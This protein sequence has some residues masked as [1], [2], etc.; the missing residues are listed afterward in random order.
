MSQPRPICLATVLAVCLLALLPASVFSASDFTRFKDL[1]NEYLKVTDVQERTRTED[2]YVETAGKVVLTKV[3]FKEVLVTAELIKRPPSTMD[4]MFSAGADPALK[5]CLAPF[6][7]SGKALDE[8]C[9]AIRFQSM[10]RGNVG[11]A[12]FRLTDEMSRY[13][14]HLTQRLPEKGSSIKL[15]VPTD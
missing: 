10:I 4:T 8:D 2:R 6:D 3:P 13:E 1:K 9:Q 15:W 11:T 7:T 12:T 14:F 5:I